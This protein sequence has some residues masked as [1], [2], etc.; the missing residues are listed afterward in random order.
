MALFFTGR[1]HAGENLS[2]VLTRRAA[3]LA[4]PVL[5]GYGLGTYPLGKHTVDVGGGAS[6]E[7]VRTVSASG[8]KQWV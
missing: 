8:S 7:I 1:R 2:A 5:M 4:P 6:L 3:D